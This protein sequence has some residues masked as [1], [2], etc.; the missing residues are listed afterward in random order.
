MASRIS[1]F[2]R[3]W[4]I[5]YYRYLYNFFKINK[6]VKC[7]ICNWEGKEFISLDIGFGRIYKKALCPSCRSHPRHRAFYFYF[8]DKEILPDNKQIKLL[9][10][11]PEKYFTE[12]FKSYQNIDYLSVDI[13][14]NIAM[15]KE[16]ITRLSFEDSTFDIIF[17]SH[18]LEHIDNDRIAMAELLRVLKKDGFAIIAVPINYNR[19][20]TY[21][22][23]SITS[24]EGRTKAFW[25][26]DHVRLY[27]RDFADRLEK[28]G[29]KVKT[30]K[31]LISMEES[32]KKL[33][34]IE[35]DLI[36]VCMK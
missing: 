9:H 18:V 11:A 4:S 3:M 12:L 20:Y 25:Q 21:E 36:Y 29:F 13:N 26:F 6:K 23:S 32:K 10:F 1:I 24:N 22:D 5:L 16:D 15:Q 19:R 8:K 27:G 2:K 33:F 34:G 28:A 31:F 7:N 17:C 35:N 30:D 14:E